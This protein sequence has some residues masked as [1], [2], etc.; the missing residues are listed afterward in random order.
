MGTI[1]TR[2]RKDGSTAF[3]AQ[4]SLMRDGKVAH[5]ESRTFDRRAAA[6][7]WLKRREAELAKPEA[8][9]GGKDRPDRATLAQAIDR[10]IAESR[11]EIGRTKTQVLNAIR[12]SDFGAMACT[13]LDS[14]AIVSYA[15]DLGRS[16]QPQ[17]VGNYLSHL[18][19][20]LKLARPAWGFPIDARAISDAYVVLN[21]LGVISKSKMRDRRPTLAELDAIVEFFIERG[22]RRPRSSPMAAIVLF[23][24]FSARRL[25]EITRIVWADFEPEARRVCVRDMKHPGQK[26]GN[27]V[28]C[29]LPAEALRLI[30]ATPRLAARIFPFGD[31]A[32][33]AAFTRACIVLGIE[34]L[35]FHDL[36]H[37][38]VSRLFEMGLNIPH[39][40]SVS[41]H[42]SWSSLRRYTHLR[43]TGDKYAGWAGLDRV[44][45]DLRAGHQAASWRAS[46]R[47]ASRR[48][49]R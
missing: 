46:L 6:V 17:T 40:A 34:N 41:G 32:V 15:Q 27:D 36:R 26:I 2:P 35:H 31:G 21:Q 43:Q 12:D 47:A 24:L 8:V 10:Y 39:V 28:W 14:Q 19:A 9:L 49:S 44:L 3:M 5:R 7:A 30:E 20:V 23:A 25:E 13:A 45:D 29:D 38:G 16:R 42:R 18:G 1:I 22:R 33:S 4:I 11:K 37:E 48:L